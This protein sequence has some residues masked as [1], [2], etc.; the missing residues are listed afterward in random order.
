LKI[1]VKIIN[2]LQSNVLKNQLPKC[3]ENVYVRREITYRKY[4]EGHSL[5]L[6]ITVKS[7]WDHQLTRALIAGAV[8]PSE[9]FYPKTKYRKS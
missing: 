4:H 3:I 8:R 2:P 6:L 5:K 7:I 1:A 9:I